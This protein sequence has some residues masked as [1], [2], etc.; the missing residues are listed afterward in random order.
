MSCQSRQEPSEHFTESTA[1]SSFTVQDSDHFL[2]R[3][4]CQVGREHFQRKFGSYSIERDGS[5]RSVANSNQ[6]LP[7]LLIVTTVSTKF[8]AGLQH[9]KPCQPPFILLQE[10]V[11]AV[12]DQASLVVRFISYKLTA[13]HF[14][15]L[16]QAAATITGLVVNVGHQELFPKH[17]G[18]KLELQGQVI[19]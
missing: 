9:L 16:N 8:A 6:C 4:D 7:L 19:D 14:K 17:S 11:T 18:L 15:K 10:L 1:R 3:N 5:A 13:C 12:E 2:G